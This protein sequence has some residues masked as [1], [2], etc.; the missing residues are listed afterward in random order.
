LIYPVLNSDE[1]VFSKL[2]RAVEE[3]EASGNDLKG[4]GIR[5]ANT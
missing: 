3:K 4:V 5:A 1:D 2:A